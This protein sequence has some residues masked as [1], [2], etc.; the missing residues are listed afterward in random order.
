MTA[1]K[2]LSSTHTRTMHCGVAGADR[3]G[4]D[5]IHAAEQRQ[6]SD[7][8]LLCCRCQVGEALTAY[9]LLS[10]THIARQCIVVLQVSS[11]RGADSVQ[12]AEKYE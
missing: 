6:R 7:N 1:Y 5:S 2:L 12:A 3:R 8:A 10:C 9:K 11:R 4:T